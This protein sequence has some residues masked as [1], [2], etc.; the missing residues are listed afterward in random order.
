MPSDGLGPRR[1]RLFRVACLGAVRG[2]GS[3]GAWRPGSVDVASTDPS[4]VDFEDLDAALRRVDAS[5]SASESHG[6]LCGLLC[7][8]PTAPSDE[9][10]AVVLEASEPGEAL[11]GESRRLLARLWGQ[12]RRQLDG[13]D[14][15]F[16]PLLPDDSRP[17]ALRTQVL[18]SWCTGFLYGLGLAEE[19]ILSRMSADAREFLTDLGELTRVEAEAT[20]DEEG[21]VAYAEV[22]EY[23]RVGVLMI[24]EDL[25]AAHGPVPAPSVH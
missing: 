21:E 8:R 10:I 6:I 22:V 9:W 11:A 15:A 19:Q 13:P 2:D 7:V 17:L 18:G 12:T 5:A 25:R 1:R 16:Q 14:Y 20:A 23:V 24:Y 3:I 4:A